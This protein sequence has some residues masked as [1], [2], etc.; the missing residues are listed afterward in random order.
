M[1]IER[2]PVAMPALERFGCTQ[3]RPSRPAESRI[4]VHVHLSGLGP[5]EALKAIARALSEAVQE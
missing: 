1:T 3:P 4:S 5:P 2:Y